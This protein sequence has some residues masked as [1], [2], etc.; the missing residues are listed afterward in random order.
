M[1]LEDRDR[2]PLSGSAAII[3][4]ARPFCR[5][6]E[7]YNFGSSASGLLADQFWTRADMLFACVLKSN[8]FFAKKGKFWSRRAKKIK[9]KQRKFHK[10]I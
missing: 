4:H 2:P 9:E 5:L 8:N 1:S 7:K 10:K 3:C 6:P